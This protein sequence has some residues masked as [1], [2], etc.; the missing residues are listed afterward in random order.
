M[1]ERSCIKHKKGVFLED[2]EGSQYCIIKTVDD[3]C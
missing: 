1:K 2:M 3:Y